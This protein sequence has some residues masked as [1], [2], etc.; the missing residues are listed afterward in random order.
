MPSSK[1]Q[2][3]SQSVVIVRLSNEERLSGKV[4]AEHVGKAVAALHRDGVVVLENAVDP[5]HMDTINE[6][7]RSEAEEMAKLPTTHFN[8]VGLSF[9]LMAVEGFL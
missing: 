7:L 4:T 5:A 8:D 3:Q 6:I 2:Y 1:P 9:W